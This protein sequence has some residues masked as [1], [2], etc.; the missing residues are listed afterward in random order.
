MT[1]EVSCWVQ[2]CLLLEIPHI[3]L[4]GDG[5]MEEKGKTACN[6]TGNVLRELPW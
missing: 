2:F 3:S 4:D 5:T 6:L 1:E